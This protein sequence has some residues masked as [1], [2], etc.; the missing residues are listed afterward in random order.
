MLSGSSPSVVASE[1]LVDFVDFLKALLRLETN[2]EASAPILTFLEG[3]RTVGVA[4]NA[5]DWDASSVADPEV[6]LSSSFPSAPSFPSFPP[7]S[8]QKR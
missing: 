4:R 7:F 2:L 6:L 5:S 3:L 8:F 1:Y